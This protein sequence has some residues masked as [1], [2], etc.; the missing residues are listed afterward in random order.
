[1]MSPEL[2]HTNWHVEA[3][4]KGV[5]KIIRGVMRDPDGVTVG[6]IT[7]NATSKGGG[8]ALVD[9][10]FGQPLCTLLPAMAMALGTPQPAELQAPAV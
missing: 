6:T 9:I 2:Q 10:L 4:V 8:T 1:M 7:F 3:A 5:K